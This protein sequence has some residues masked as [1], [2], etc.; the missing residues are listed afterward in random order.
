MWCALNENVDITEENQFYNILNITIN[1]ML[2]KHQ[3][4]LTVLLNKQLFNLIFKSDNRIRLLK[5]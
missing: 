5:M 4:F 2:E 1:L 3:K